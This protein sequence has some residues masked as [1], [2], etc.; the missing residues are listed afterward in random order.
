[1]HKILFPK[2]FPFY[3]KVFGPR[4]DEF[5]LFSSYKLSQDEINLFKIMLKLLETNPKDK[6]R[7][8]LMKLLKL[9]E[10]INEKYFADFIETTIRF[11]RNKT[12]H[13]K[14]EVL[15]KYIEERK[16]DEINPLY[17]YSQDEQFEIEYAGIAVNIRANGNLTVVESTLPY[18]VDGDVYHIGGHGVSNIK[19][20]VRIARCI[21]NPKSFH[22]LVDTCISI[23]S[24]K[25]KYLSNY[26]K[27]ILQNYVPVNMDEF[28]IKI[29]LTAFFSINKPLSIQYGFRDKYIYEV[30]GYEISK[31]ETDL[32]I[33]IKNIYPNTNYIYL[34]DVRKAEELYNSLSGNDFSWRFLRRL[35]STREKTKLELDSPFLIKLYKL[36]IL[37]SATTK[38]AVV[39]YDNYEVNELTFKK[40]ENGEWVYLDKGSKQISKLTKRFELSWLKRQFIDADKTSKLGLK[41]IKWDS[42]DCAFNVYNTGCVKTT[43]FDDII[44]PYYYIYQLKKPDELFL[45]LFEVAITPYISMYQIRSIVNFINSTNVNLR[46]P[47]SIAPKYLH[48]LCTLYY[49]LVYDRYG[50]IDFK[51]QAYL[52]RALLIGKP[53]THITNHYTYDN[54]LAYNCEYAQG[55]PKVLLETLRC[56]TNKLIDNY[57]DANRPNEKPKIFIKSELW[58]HQITNSNNIIN[59]YKQNARGFCD[60]SDVGAGK[61]LTALNVAKTLIEEPSKYYGVIVIVPV[62][63]LV[64]SWIT[65]IETHTSG[66]EIVNHVEDIVFD[67]KQNTIV[68]AT[69]DS[70]NVRMIYHKW[71]FCIVDECV[72]FT[73]MANKLKNS[74]MTMYLCD[75]LLLLSATLYRSNKDEI[76]ILSQYLDYRLEI[77]EPKVF[78]TNYVTS[79]I[80]VDR[81]HFDTWFHDMIDNYENGTNISEIIQTILSKLPEDR[82]CVIYVTAAQIKECS[83]KLGIPIYKPNSNHDH[84]HVLITFKDG[85]FGIN[86]L[87]KYNTLVMRPPKSHLLTQLKGRLDRPGQMHEQLYIEYY[88]I[89]REDRYRYNN[90]KKSQ[91]FVETHIKPIASFI[92]ITDE[93][94][95]EDPDAETIIL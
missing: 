1:M 77:E 46:D 29:Y 23:L 47:T 38:N 63:T 48:I 72:E 31:Y 27:Q 61:T 32:S 9:P 41:Y 22:T 81:K 20:S 13:T 4:E 78:M 73:G 36:S 75:K 68:V 19:H 54:L 44:H 89:L 82:K 2:R 59:A 60:A 91:Q 16:S 25:D 37:N 24:L 92:Q 90:L 76:R 80:A 86:D 14:H 33:I 74:I 34:N 66:F 17:H 88:A 50:D 39:T 84:K 62:D 8:K 51:F 15:K 21:T 6:T 49:I 43:S 55:A 56:I 42:T 64:D 52:V 18:F 87:V 70:L 45:K 69:I 28:K 12:I 58:Q 79:T 93:E 10:E 7:I 94:E 95:E 3:P 71:R 83:K 40:Y 85:T 53:M 30:I 26:I 67:I 35:D 5:P 57:M 11:M 65:E